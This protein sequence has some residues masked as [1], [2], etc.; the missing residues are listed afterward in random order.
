[1]SSLIQQRMAIERIRTSA[2]VWTLSG[3][4][5]ALLAIAKFVMGTEPM[6]AAVFF[7][8][9]GG[10][11]IGGLVRLRRYRREIAG[12]TAENGVDAGKR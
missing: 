7:G 5:W 1:M 10:W 12:Y 8:I 11:I 9:A 2:I 3:G 4:F 6:W